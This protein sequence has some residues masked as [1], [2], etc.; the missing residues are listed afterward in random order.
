MKRLRC[1]EDWDHWR[2]CRCKIRWATVWLKMNISTT[3]WSCR[4]F[5][6]WTKIDWWWN[7]DLECRWQ[8]KIWNV[9]EWLTSRS[10]TRNPK[11]HLSDG[12]PI[13]F[14]FWFLGRTRKD[15]T[16]D[17]SCLIGVLSQVKFQWSMLQWTEIE[18]G[19]NRATGAS[20]DQVFFF[21]KRSD[22]VLC[23]C[24][25]MRKWGVYEKIKKLSM[26]VIFHWI[27]YA[28]FTFT[29]VF[30]EFRVLI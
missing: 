4:Y 25:F 8:E 21:L 2:S 23:S 6:I 3:G 12:C 24:E 13:V 20:S 14:F 30:E 10:D 19:C 7:C 17:W 16:I 11:D 9:M 5:L 18:L 15:Q 27:V 28:I 22:Q 29:W 26:F 1:A